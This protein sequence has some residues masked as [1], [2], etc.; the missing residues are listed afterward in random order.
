MF[1]LFNNKNTIITFLSVSLLILIIQV[2]LPSIIIFG[3][4]KINLDL[5]LV[6]LTFLIFFEI[7]IYK[8]I[9][10]AFIYGLI[11]DTIINIDQIGL[12]SFIKSFTVYLLSYILKY[13]TI[14]KWQIKL[15]YIFLIYFVHFFIY[16]IIIYHDIYMYV[17]IAGIF[18]A[19]LCILIFIILNKLLFNSKMN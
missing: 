7:E 1:S 3:G 10:L 12:L 8:L 15:L 14:W 2:N 9:I 16:Y 6:F 13:Q 5:F 19:V 11:Q 4:N 17:L 18:Q